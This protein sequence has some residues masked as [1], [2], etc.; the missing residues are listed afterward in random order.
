MLKLGQE[1][2]H[3]TSIAVSERSC[4]KVKQQLQD[5]AEGLLKKQAWWHTG[6]P[7]A[8]SGACESIWETLPVHLF[9]FFFVS[10]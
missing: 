8:A 4:Q 7:L 3:A 9:V 6:G 10:G 2:D 1:I 5:L